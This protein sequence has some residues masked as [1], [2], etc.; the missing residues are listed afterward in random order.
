MTPEP[1]EPTFEDALAQLETIVRELEDGSTGLEE[2]LARYEAGIALLKQC[3]AKLRD[4]EQRIV[5]LAGCDEEGRPLDDLIV[6]D[7]N[8]EHGIVARR[9]AGPIDFARFPIGSRLRVLPNHACATAAQHAEYH[10]LREGRAVETW[11]R[12]GGW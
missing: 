5:K 7:A 6:V 12:F 8:Q 1:T 11:E 3:Y 10:V 4:A 2:S 9:D